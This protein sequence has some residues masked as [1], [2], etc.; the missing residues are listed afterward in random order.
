MIRLTE[1]QKKERTERIKRVSKKTQFSGQRAVECGRKGNRKGVE[2]RERM[3]SLK[4]CAE[5]VAQVPLT[6]ERIKMFETLGLNLKKIDSKDTMAL[7]GVVYGQFI[8]AMNG[9]KPSADFVK[10]LMEGKQAEESSAQSFIDAL[11]DKADSLES[12]GDDVEE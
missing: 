3:K 8:A 6:E 1:E 2:N 4:E 10:E 5:M 7:M 12:A 11:N 9:S